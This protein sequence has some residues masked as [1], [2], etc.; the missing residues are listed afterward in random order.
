M[1]LR[2]HIRFRLGT[3]QKRGGFRYQSG[4]AFREEQERHR[5]GGGV[6]GVVLRA[7]TTSR[8]TVACG[9]KTRNRGS[10]S[11]RNRRDGW[12]ERLPEALYPALEPSLRLAAW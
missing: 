7:A 6:T 9:H 5:Q 10:V 2:G 4:S 1:S 12:P 3:V 8:R 11:Q